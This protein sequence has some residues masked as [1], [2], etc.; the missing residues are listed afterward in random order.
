MLGNHV[1]TTG[2]LISIWTILWGCFEVT[3]W[4]EIFF[5]NSSEIFMQKPL[6]VNKISFLDIKHGLIMT[7]DF[8]KIKLWNYVFA[9]YTWKNFQFW[10]HIIW[11]KNEWQKNGVFSDIKHGL[12]MT[13]YI[14][15][16]NY[17]FYTI[18]IYGLHY[19]TIRPCTKK[20]LKLW[21]PNFQ[22]S[23]P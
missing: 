13:S 22:K 1:S 14:L 6:K 20:K 3:E 9:R 7:S 17:S 12:T 21:P 23:L 4:L 10:C 18:P 2:C 16:L 19:G 15:K 5:F 11:K 8:Q